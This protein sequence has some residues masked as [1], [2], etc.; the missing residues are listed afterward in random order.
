MPKNGSPRTI[1]KRALSVAIGTGRR[2][3]KRESRY[4]N[5]SLSGRES[6]SA[7][8]RRKRGESELTRSPSS[9]RTAGRTISATPAAISATSAPP[10]PI[11]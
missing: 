8:R 10:I 11:E 9:V 4:Q 3:T 1:R 7:R 5:P 6:A 2:I